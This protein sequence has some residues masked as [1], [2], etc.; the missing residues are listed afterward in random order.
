MQGPRTSH[1][2]IGG[3]SV[4]VILMLV[5]AV[6]LPAP[7]LPVLAAS[8]SALSV[9]APV[10]YSMGPSEIPSGNPAYG[11]QSGHLQSIAVDYANPSL[12]FVGGGVSEGV[13]GPYSWAGVYKTTNNGSSWIP[14]DNGLRNHLV[15]ALWMN[16]TDPNIVLAGTGFPTSPF[17]GNAWATA[18]PDPGIYRT[19][20][21]G[22]SW[23]LVY[24]T[25][26]AEGF[27]Q[28]GS[29]IYAGVASG[30]VESTDGG[31]KWTMVFKTSLSVGVLA[32]GGNRI[33]A[34]LTNGSLYC[35]DGS[36]SWKLLGSWPGLPM[37]SIAIDS[38]NSSIIYVT[39]RGL[40]MTQNGGLSWATLSPGAA[41]VALDP[42]NA[43]MVYVGNLQTP[44]TSYETQAMFVSSNGGGSFTPTGLGVDVHSLTTWPGRGGVVYVGSD[45][46]IFWTSNGGNK[47][48]SI[49]GK[50]PVS[51]LTSVS[52]SGNH[53]FVGA[54]DF[55][56]LQSFDNGSTWAPSGGAEDG[57]VLINPMNP[58]NLYAFSIGGFL[59]SSDGG[60]TFS[61]NAQIS[62]SE[63]G[64]QGM[65]QVIAVDKQNPSVVY[66]AGLS[67]IFKSIDWGK[68]FVKMNW[69]FTGTSLVL[70]SPSD[71]KTIFVGTQNGTLYLSTNGGTKW[72][73]CGLPTVAGRI[74]S[75]SID[76]L[77]LSIL[78]VG[79]SNQPPSGG[80]FW[81]GNDCSSFSEMN[82]GLS[83]QTVMAPNGVTQLSF[84]PNST[85][86][87]VEI[88]VAIYEA[89]NVGGTWTNI[90]G[91]LFPV[92]FTGLAWS[93]GYLYTSSYG[94]GVSRT[95]LPTYN[96][97]TFVESGLPPSTS[98]S[99]VLNGTAA[100]SKMH[101]VSFAA[102]NGVYPFTVP[103][104][105][106]FQVNPSSGIVNVTG[107]N[108]TVSIVFSAVT[109]STATSPSSTSSSQ[110]V[111]PTVTLA[112]AQVSGL[113][114]T[115]NGAAIP[116]ATIT[117]ISWQWG[118]GQ[119]TSGFFPQTHT[120]SIAGTYKVIVTATNSAGLSGSSS[121]NVI[122]GSS[123]ASTAQ[124][125]TTAETS[126]SVTTTS[127]ATSTGGG[128]PEFPFQALATSV[129]VVAIVLTYIVNRRR[130]LSKF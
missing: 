98:W 89:P 25:A 88:G 82:S 66:V 110:P 117:N 75:L 20:D 99:V 10:W 91:S 124:I 102:L 55:S 73:P 100:S 12:M 125:S 90:A 105:S 42:L 33:C 28:Y 34:G 97:V 47:W 86:L 115:I 48:S 16:Q 37:G 23:S 24:P 80:V 21:G 111:P 116:G 45:Q 36:A 72:K 129:I 107:A 13:V 112:P 85:R 26:S 87:V 46:G 15:D 113:T 58:S 95:L 119:T 57:Q 38:Q 63:Y 11:P 61:Q 1:L 126:S 123:S 109:T 79:T 70:V 128:I 18:G 30:V 35:V 27:V 106:G 67:G 8:T 62:P 92:W 120:Y 93:G 41:L 51:L 29:T 71:S 2:L 39:D 7:L 94:H 17:T 52:V 65:N 43:E 83:A 69:G 32:I 96:Y 40:Y 68:T 54:Q 6:P 74:D 3:A 130:M 60:R 49:T 114:V 77:N 84:A 19:I 4:T 50:L 127:K 59:Y 76:P 78:V 121:E 122:V 118:D 104:V 56:T 64:F 108:V 5:L 22:A 103:T 53:L 9:T 14:V 44:G 81:S 31:L 101:A